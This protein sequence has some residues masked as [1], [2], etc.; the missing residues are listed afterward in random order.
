M[1]PQFPAIQAAK[2]I[3]LL[4]LFT[5]TLA[6]AVT[7]RI[8]EYAVTVVTFGDS[9]T[10]P[11]EN[12]EVY[13]EILEKQLR[14]KNPAARVINAGVRG[15][16]T[17][18]A[19]RRF[20]K[21]VLDNK[22][23]LVVLQFGINDSAVDVWKDPPADKPRVDLKNFRNHLQYFI[24]TLK[25]RGVK[26]VLMT[27]NPLRWTSRLRELYGKPPYHPEDPEG[28]NWLLL[29]YVA[30]VR[31]LALEESLELVDVDAA[32]RDYARRHGSLDDL[33]L[34]GMHPNQQGQRIVAEMLAKTLLDLLALR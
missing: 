22:P 20:Q 16:N 32:F 9:T 4:F 3:A 8:P 28:M 17:E 21:D 30:A 11:R 18:D 19:A 7:D 6:R 10:A 12:L 2:H 27:P 23:D 26:V 33:L 25:S 29:T 1:S 13:S 24:S 34:D 5:G 31:E 15:N 14:A